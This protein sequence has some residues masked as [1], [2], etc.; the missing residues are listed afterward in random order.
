[1]DHGAGGAAAAVGRR[2][3]VD[4]ERVGG[5]AGGGGG[6]DAPADGRVDR[7]VGGLGLL[8]LLQREAVEVL[9]VRDRDRAAVEVEARV[10]DQR[11]HGGL[12]VLVLRRDGDGDVDG[13]DAGGVEGGVVHQRRE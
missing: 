3:A 10:L 7:A 4:H 13:V 12:E 5:A 9:L 1:G 2:L 11:R 6:V 8:A